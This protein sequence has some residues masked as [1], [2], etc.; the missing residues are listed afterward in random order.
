MYSKKILA[1]LHPLFIYPEKHRLM[2]NTNFPQNKG[3][4]SFLSI[5]LLQYI[6]APTDNCGYGLQ[7][8]TK[9]LL[10]L[11]EYPLFLSDFNQNRNK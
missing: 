3:V 5:A 6:L 10:Y 8:P 7:I 2:E 4:T 9:T 11:L 1:F